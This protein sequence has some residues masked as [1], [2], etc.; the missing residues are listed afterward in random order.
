VRVRGDDN[1]LRVL[2]RDE[3][4]APLNLVPDLLSKGGISRF[5]NKI[6]P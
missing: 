6:S 2:V 5:I 4:L 1:R 3:Q